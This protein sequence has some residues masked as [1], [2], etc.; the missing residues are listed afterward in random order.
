[1]GAKIFS[2]S[3][4][5]VHSPHSIGVGAGGARGDR[6]GERRGEVVGGDVRGDDIMTTL[7][8]GRRIIVPPCW[9][10]RTTAALAGSD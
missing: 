1:V 9:L 5:S 4:V 8:S 3:A 10:Q 2:L 7:L 6:R